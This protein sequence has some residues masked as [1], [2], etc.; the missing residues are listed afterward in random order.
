MGQLK[1]EWFEKACKLCLK[2]WLLRLL[3]RFLFWVSSSWWLVDFR[4][5]FWSKKKGLG[6]FAHAP[7]RWTISHS[8]WCVPCERDISVF[9]IWQ[10]KGIIFFSFPSF[11]FLSSFLMAAGLWFLHVLDW[12]FLGVNLMPYSG[13]FSSKWM[14]WVRHILASLPIGFWGFII[15]LLNI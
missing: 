10:F 5:K 12:S 11:F 15:P 14:I 9:L 1:F 6:R 13:G 4:L 2:P 7:H 8:L 3:G